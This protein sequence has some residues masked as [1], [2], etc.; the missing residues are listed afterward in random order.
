MN[1]W[2]KW[3]SFLRK[4]FWFNYWT[5][6]QNTSKPISKNRRLR[7]RRP[8]WKIGEQLKAI[9]YRNSIIEIE[10]LLR[11]SLQPALHF[12]MKLKMISLTSEVKM[13]NNE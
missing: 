7:S 11:K 2:N 4:K 3:T 1:L 13:M 10:A 12:P 8:L 6:R 5:T 9:C